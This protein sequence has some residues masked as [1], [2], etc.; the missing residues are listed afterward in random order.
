GSGLTYISPCLSAAP[1]PPPPNHHP[2]PLRRPS[3]LPPLSPAGVPPTAAPD[4]LAAQAPPRQAA[5]EAPAAKAEKPGQSGRSEQAIVLL[6]NDEPITAYEIQQRA[7]FL[8]L[9]GGAGLTPELK[10]KA[11]PPWAQITNDPKIN[12]RLNTL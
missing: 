6:V 11:E 1:A 7:N 3:P 12:D 9:Q 2:P 5:A 4:R 10:A 8:A